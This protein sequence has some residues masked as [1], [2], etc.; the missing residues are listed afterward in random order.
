MPFNELVRN[1][2]VAVWKLIFG[3]G[4]RAFVR[5]RF[6]KILAAGRAVDGVLASRAAADWTDIAAYAGTI[7]PGAFFLTNFAGNVQG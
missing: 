1:A 7:T 6:L 2:N 5:S 3:E 4:D